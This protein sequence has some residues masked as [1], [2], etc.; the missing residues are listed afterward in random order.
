VTP[1]E[2]RGLSFR[3]THDVTSPGRS[4]LDAVKV[5]HG[6]VCGGHTEVVDADLPGCFDS[7]PGRSGWVA[8][9]DGSAT[10][11]SF[12]YVRNTG[13]GSNFSPSTSAAD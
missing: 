11:S 5:G 1:A 10:E 4:A 9:A 8:S 7:V 2:G 12:S 3:S 6:L 13:S